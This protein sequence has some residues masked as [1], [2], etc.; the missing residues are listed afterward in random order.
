MALKERLT[1]IPP[2]AWV[3]GFAAAGVILLTVNHWAVTSP[4]GARWLDPEQ[5]ALQIDVT[6]V[7][8]PQRTRPYPGSVSDWSCSRVGDC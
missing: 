1:A 3:V 4:E 7:A 8:V 6:P 5:P 2:W